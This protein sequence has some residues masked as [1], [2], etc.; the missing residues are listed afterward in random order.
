MRNIFIT[1]LVISLVATY[2][3][4]AER[5][6]TLNLMGALKAN[7]IYNLKRQNLIAQN[8]EHADI[9]RYKAVDMKERAFQK[10]IRRS[11]RLAPVSVRLTSPRHINIQRNPADAMFRVSKDGSYEQ[12]PS[13]NTVNI[14]EQMIKSS[15]ANM[16]Y[17][18]TTTM[19]K[20][21]MGM[22]RTAIS[23]K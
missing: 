12:S 5:K 6:K 18:L 10:G 4:S 20:R 22:M 17:T 19:Y 2:S 11:T 15:E 13:K 1:A 3:Y 9:P 21:M 7:M 23:N 8:I 16:E 14:E